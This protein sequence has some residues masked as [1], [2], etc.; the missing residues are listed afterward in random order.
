M[1][2]TRAAAFACAALVA[3]VLGPA[4]A[5]GGLVGDPTVDVWTHAWGLGWVAERLSHGALPIATTALGFPRGGSVTPA[6]PLGALLVL[7]VTLTLGVS[8]AYLVELGLQLALAAGAGWAY[9]KAV[10]GP[11]GGFV[12]AAACTTS[13]TF[14]AELHNGILEANWIG[15][16]PL[17][18]AAALLRPRWTPAAVALAAAASPYHGVA[19]G[20][21]AG[22]HLLARREW[23]TF[24]LTALAGAAALGAATALLHLGFSGAEPLEVKPPGLQEPTLRVNAVDP[25]AFFWPGDHWTVDLASGGFAP[26]FRRTPYLGWTLVLAA[27][28]GTARAPKRAWLWAP[29]TLGAVLALGP[30]LWWNGDWYAPGGAGRLALP[31]FPLLKLTDGQLDHPLRFLSMA[32]PALAALAA[33][34]AGRFAPLLAALVV[35]ENLAVAPNVWPLPTVDATIPAVYAEIPAD[36]RAIIDLPAQVGET[37]RTGAYLYWQTAHGHPI[38]YTLKPSAKVPSMNATLRTWLALSAPM[39][40]PRGSPGWID[41]ASD[42]HAALD[43]LIA[44]GFGWVILHRSLCRDQ[45]AWNDHERAVSAL[46]GPGRRVGDDELWELNA[47]GA[48]RR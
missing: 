15:L 5:H 34:G 22:A 33:L 14:T 25:R 8:G 11:W 12:V 21:L 10:A 36:G 23:R 19:A 47:A 48:A 31:L 30:Y 44:Q 45:P 3:I 37:M 20:I 24:A 41:P 17:A 40:I 43:E 28:V 39:Q 6:D 26:N 2:G 32:I 35:A 13:P 29:V 16:V 38:P 1:T 4:L 18:A 27:L 9:G 42:L 46:V 7:P